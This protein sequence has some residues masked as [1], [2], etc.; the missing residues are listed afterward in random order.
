MIAIYESVKEAS[1]HTGIKRAS[2]QVAYNNP[3]NYYAYGFYWAA[4][5]LVDKKREVLKKRIQYGRSEHEVLC[6]TT[7]ERFYNL[8]EAAE[9]YNI[10]PGSISACCCGKTKYSGKHPITKQ[11]LEWKYITTN[12]A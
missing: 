4:E 2:V 7:G 10:L 9:H 6:I 8:K 5:D 1:E 12:A 11:C 3:N